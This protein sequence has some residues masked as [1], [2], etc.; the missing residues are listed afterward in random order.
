MSFVVDIL[1]LFGLETVPD[2][3]LKIGQ[4]FSNLLVTLV[5]NSH[6]NILKCQLLI[7]AYILLLIDINFAYL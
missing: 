7:S 2:T 4:F 1:A 6:E 5:L 3:F